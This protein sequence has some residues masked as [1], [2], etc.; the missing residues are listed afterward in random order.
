MGCGRYFEV[1]IEQIIRDMVEFYG[2]FDGAQ[3]THAH[4]IAGTGKPLD[5]KLCFPTLF[6][7]V[8]LGRK[9]IL[10]H[11]NGGKLCQFGLCLVVDNGKFKVTVA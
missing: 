6:C 7:P 10:A 3:G 11:E 9:A 1:N 5:R 2:K 4:W 8:H